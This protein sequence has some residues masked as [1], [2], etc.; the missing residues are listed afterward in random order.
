MHKTYPYECSLAIAHKTRDYLKT[1]TWLELRK[2]ID[3]DKTLRDK[4]P[5]AS[6][7]NT[8]VKMMSILY[9]Y[10]DAEYWRQ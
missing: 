8:I 6:P 7:E 4:V 3:R 9:P 2:I 5:Y 1:L 10:V